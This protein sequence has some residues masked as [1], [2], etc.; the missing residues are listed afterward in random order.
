MVSCFRDAMIENAE[1]GLVFGNVEHF[2]ETGTYCT[3]AGEEIEV[4]VTVN[5]RK[6]DD[7]GE[8]ILDRDQEELELSICINPNAAR[9]G[10]ANPGDGDTYLR[11][12]ENPESP[13]SFQRVLAETSGEWKLMFARRPPKRYGQ[14]SNP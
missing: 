7:A 2:G 12:G 14:G 10:V 8:Q 6:L 5:Y 13:W 9:G 11:A 4:D 3:A 1:S